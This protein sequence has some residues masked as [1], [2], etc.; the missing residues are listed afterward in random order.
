MAPRKGREP[1]SGRP[2]S[3]LKSATNERTGQLGKRPEAVPLSMPKAAG[4]TEGLDVYARF[5][6]FQQSVHAYLAGHPELGAHLEEPVH[7]H[8]STN[9]SFKAGVP[10]QALLQAKDQIRKMIPQHN[11]TEFRRSPSKHPGEP[12]VHV[13]KL[14]RS[15]VIRLADQH[16]RELHSSPTQE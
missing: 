16:M 11:L 14:I 13:S 1:E 3:P 10:T 15:L 4:E 6:T 12:M 5:S 7:G 2:G 9:F 8:I